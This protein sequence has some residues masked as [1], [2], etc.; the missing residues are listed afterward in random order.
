MLPCNT[1]VTVLFHC[2]RQVLIYNHWEDTGHSP[3]S[4]VTKALAVMSTGVKRFR[5]NAQYLPGDS[6][7]QSQGWH[8]NA[9]GR[10]LSK[11]GRP[12]MKGLSNEEALAERAHSAFPQLE[13]RFIEKS[14]IIY[15]L[16][17]KCTAALPCGSEVLHDL[18]CVWMCVCGCICAFICASTH[19]H[20]YTQAQIAKF[21]CS[22]EHLSW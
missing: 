8:Y 9:F 5:D 4:W 7:Q 1:K 21:R 16:C 14:F 2:S 22:T 12:A 6:S 3:H 19:V 15:S 17:A 10:A 13:P 20:T 11:A 18:K